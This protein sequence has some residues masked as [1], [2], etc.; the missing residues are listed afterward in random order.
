MNNSE[1]INATIRDVRAKLA[2]LPEI[3]ALLPSVSIVAMH[4]MEGKQPEVGTLCCI[5]SARPNTNNAVLRSCI[6]TCMT[7][8]I[9]MA[10]ADEPNI[11]LRRREVPGAD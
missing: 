4:A 10:L 9:A 7:V 6:L 2:E 8:G 1:V 5:I 3:K 11:S